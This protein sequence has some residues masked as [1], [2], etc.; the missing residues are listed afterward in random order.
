MTKNASLT[1]VILLT[2][3]GFALR[4][5]HIGSASFRGDEAFTAI[6]WASEPLTDTLA[7][8]ATVDP[9]PPLSYAMFRGWRLVFGVNEYTLRILPA[10]LNIVGVP[11]MYAL[12][13]RLGGRS[14]GILAAFLWAFHPYQ[15]WHSQ[16]ARNYA[17]WAGMSA[18]SLWLGLRAIQRQQR[19]AWL[20]YIVAAALSAYV[21][22]LELFI[23]AA[24]NLFI[25]LTT[26]RNRKLLTQWF[27]SQIII[28]LILLPWYFQERLLSGGGYGGTT[29]GF[30]A[31]KLF[32]WF[33]PTLLFGESLPANTISIVWPLALFLLL[34]GLI[35]IWRRDQHQG[36][37][38]VVLVMTPTVLLC[39]LSFRLNI[40]TPRYIL[41]IVPGLL[42]LISFGVVWS[43]KSRPSVSV[44]AMR[45]AILGLYCLVLIISLYNHFFVFDY[46]K[47]DWRSLMGY[48]SNNVASDD[49]VI[50]AAADEAFN[51]YYNLPGDRKQLPANPTQ[52]QQEITRI[53]NT[54][55]AA[56]DS[57]WL[58][59][60]TFPDWPS[61]GI[62]E[63][64]LEQNMQLV[65]ATEVKGLRVQQYMSWDTQV[66]YQTLAVFGDTVEL[67]DFYVSPPEPTDKLTIWLYWR[68][69]KT[70]EESLKSFVHLVGAV[71]PSTN[72]PLWSQDDQFPQDGLLTS[73]TWTTAITYRDVYEIPLASVPTGKYMLQVGFYNPVSGQRLAVGNEQSYTLQ[74]ITIP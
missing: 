56:H 8:I 1:I 50:Q 31:V 28:G 24:L 34:A 15:I 37:F 47:K 64:W 73:T 60:Q 16:D 44:L 13:R 27:T 52:P 67:V 23:L 71:N 53:L 21:Y 66:T 29:G 6:H 48:L 59:A 22:Y 68:P 14:V 9:H 17:I 4:V 58:V 72:T 51:Y 61:A 69:L 35:A 49:L 39:L 10:L 7:N 19:L 54:D 33:L 36:L 26:W 74:T 63:T 45:S 5:Y 65:R 41:G 11:A 12:G 18:T 30:D 38:V 2:V 40:F 42:L 3:V 46:A 20:V 70:S 62:V 43:F 32:S 25:L 57:I 55:S